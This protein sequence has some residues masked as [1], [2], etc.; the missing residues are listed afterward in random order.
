MK[1]LIHIHKTSLFQFGAIIGEIFS[2]IF[3]PD[4]KLDRDK[5]NDLPADSKAP[6]VGSGL[7]EVR[8]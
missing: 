1:I 6:D 7:P 5:I 4:L 3:A 2:P 8:V